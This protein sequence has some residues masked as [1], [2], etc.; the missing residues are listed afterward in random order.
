MRTARG[1]LSGA[2]AAVAGAVAVTV[3][4]AALRAASLRS[5][6][7]ESLGPRERL[8]ALRAIY[9]SY[10][11]QGAHRDPDAFFPAPPPIAPRLRRVRALPEGG[12]VLD[13]A[14]D[15]GYVPFLPELRDRY[16]SH[17]R[18][19]T[20]HA[21]L[22]LGPRPRPAVVLIHGYAAGQWRLEEMV[23]PL[24]WLHRRGLDVAIALLP[25]H[26]L[27]RRGKG[28]PPFPAAD[29]RQTNE[30]FRQAMHDLRGL[31]D[32]LRRRGAPSVGAM[33]MSLGG[34]STALLMSLDRELSFGAP[35][36]PLAS[37]A[38]FAREHGRL[39]EDRDGEQHALLDAVHRLVSPLHRRTLLPPER[40]LVIGG[41][42]D[43]ITPIGHA[44]RLA[45]HL[46]APLCRFPGS[47]LLQVGIGQGY[48][49]LARRILPQILPQT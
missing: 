24:R 6:R 30:G 5:G 11:R 9:D 29:P 32:W 44:E 49:E 19:R 22:Y 10:E 18:N 39:R 12:E 47:H 46:G 23:W 36:I 20:A 13:A 28:P 21:R 14:W 2:A 38:D 25:F 27:R 15:S 48:R 26:A 42:V 8:E 31:V 1:L 45:A 40:I 4:R 17:E 43:R 3:D 41:E 7:A 35:I 16:L 34:Y 37:L 33:G